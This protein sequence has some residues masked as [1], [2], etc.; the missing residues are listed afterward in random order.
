MMDKKNDP[1]VSVS[2]G[3]A[4]LHEDNTSKTYSIT[5]LT[6]SNPPQVESTIGSFN[7]VFDPL[8]SKNEKKLLFEQKLEE[9]IEFRT[10]FQEKINTKFEDIMIKE[11]P[12]L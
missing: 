10:I 6:N 12:N 8:L 7:I 5:V 1:K 9:I 11:F 2:L 3:V 4:I